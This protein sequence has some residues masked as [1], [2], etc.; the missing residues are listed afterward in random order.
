MKGLSNIKALLFRL[1]TIVVLY[2]LIRLLFYL[3]NLSLFQGISTE[4]AITIFFQ[5]IRFDITIIIYINLLFIIMSS[6]PFPIH[7]NR[8]YAIIQKGVYLIFN[9]VGIFIA[10]ADIAFYRFNS[11]RLDSEALSLVGTFPKMLGSFIADYWYL[12]LL[13]IAIGY[14]LSK[15]YNS[16]GKRESIVQV[17]FIKRIIAFILVLSF[18]LLGIRGGFQNRPLSPAMANSKVRMELAPLITNSPMT[19][20]FSLANRKLEPKSYYSDDEVDKIFPIKKTIFPTVD[21]ISKIKPNIV[22]LI[23]ESFSAEYMGF[24][25]QSSN[26][27]PV[28]DS[29]SKKSLVFKR[30]FANGRRSSQGLVAIISGIPALMD[31]PV[32]YSQ[33]IGNNLFALP[34]LLNK[35]GYQTA[36]FNASSKE[37]LGWQN[38]IGKA[39]FEHYL[40]KEDYNKPENDDGHWGTYD[41]YFLG[42]LNKKLGEFKQPFFAT[43]FTISSHDPYLIPEDLQSKFGKNGN[44]FNALRYADWSLGE[45][46]KE[47]SK[48]PWFDNTIF[49]LSADH[50]NGAAW[51][52]PDQNQAN[53][54]RANNRVGI[55]HIPIMIYAPKLIPAAESERVI[56]QMDIFNTV[57]SL[58]DYQDSFYSFGQSVFSE[59]PGFA[60]QYVN[61][62]YQLIEG[63]Y[64]LLFQ[65]DKAIGLYNYIQDIDLKSNLINKEKNRLEY[66]QRKL[67][68]IIQQHNNTLNRNSM[69]L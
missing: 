61:G 11:K 66:M 39:G 8:K 21:S 12:L 65:N 68:A 34:Y 49:I 41:H 18:S 28:M 54:K 4:E 5:G 9:L 2:S 37:M 20:F 57:L 64:I 32:M 1:L 69:K 29:L 23:L 14:T 46:F 31:D 51:K 26:Y 38:F 33:Y 10:L 17:S 15:V 45:F 47:V 53:F 6:L 56:Q 35:N 3:Y 16:V 40:N 59:K 58:V 42:Y 22:I 55:Y 25:T 52:S 60:V 27:T 63:D 48:Q 62:I 36:F 30:A 24:L 44:Y 43:F 50:T 7:S 19:F 67:K 13:F